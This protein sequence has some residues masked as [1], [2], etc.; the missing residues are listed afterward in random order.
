VELAA[1]LGLILI[2]ALL[3]VVG[4]LI[5]E[6]HAAQT[7]LEKVIRDETQRLERKVDMFTRANTRASILAEHAVVTAERAKGAH[8]ALASLADDETHTK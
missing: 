7:A 2:V 3:L 1:A 8:P 5:R 4:H 6:G